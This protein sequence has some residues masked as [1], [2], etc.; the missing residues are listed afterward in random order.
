M[1][2][3]GMNLI[4][5]VKKNCQQV[6]VTG[7]L[8]YKFLGDDELVYVKKIVTGTIEENCYIIYQNDT[9]LI[10]D[11]GDETS[12]IKNHLE[13]LNVRPIAILLTHTHFDHIGSV[14][15]LRVDYDIPVYVHPKEQAWLSNPEKNLS[16]F[17]SHLITAEPAEFEFTANQILTI[18]NFQ[19]KVVETPGH[20][21]GS[22]SFIF[23]E[24]EFAIVGDTLFCQTIGRTDLEDGDQEQ[25]LHSIERELMTLPQHFKV[26][27]GHGSFTR[28][29]YE[30]ERNPFFKGRM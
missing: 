16:A 26:Y 25:L 22:V 5:H 6:N 18:G 30:K 15:D 10:I 29:E 28:I 3:V 27:P 8:V 9:A 20:S 17:T 14:Q 13:E 4:Y 7:F 11:P 21:P 19:F 12:K 24:D 23:Q 2:Y 1:W